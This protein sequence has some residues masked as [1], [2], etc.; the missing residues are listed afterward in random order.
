MGQQYSLPVPASR[1]NFVRSTKIRLCPPADKIGKSGRASKGALGVR[2]K[3][4]LPDEPEA[5]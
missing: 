1:L 3:N 4:F 5:E 2:V